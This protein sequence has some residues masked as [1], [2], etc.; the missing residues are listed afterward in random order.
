MPKLTNRIA[1]AP[2][3]VAMAPRYT[4]IAAIFSPATSCVVGLGI[5]IQLAVGSKPLPSFGWRSYCITCR[6]STTHCT[7]DSPPATCG[8]GHHSASQCLPCL[9]PKPYRQRR[10]ENLQCCSGVDLGAVCHHLCSLLQQG[11]RHPLAFDRVSPR[12]RVDR[13]CRDRPPVR[14]P[15]SAPSR[16]AGWLGVRQQPGLCITPGPRREGWQASCRAWR[17][18]AASASQSPLALPLGFFSDPGCVPTKIEVPS[19]LQQ[20]AQAHTAAGS[21]V[22]P[23]TFCA[24]WGSSIGLLHRGS[25]SRERQAGFVASRFKIL[26]AVLHVHLFSSSLRSRLE[27]C[28][29]P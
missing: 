14:P 21:R 25:E 28:T 12:R 13:T 7:V 15:G 5:R 24:A 6:Q 20:P 23:A 8:P 26:A 2:V 1:S 22:P 19:A 29:R 3:T 17:T 10:A 18:S 16:R 9:V 11:P 27:M 4:W